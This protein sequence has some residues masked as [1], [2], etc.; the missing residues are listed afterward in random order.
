M[1]SDFDVIDKKN[2][3]KE[4]TKNVRCPPTVQFLLKVAKLGGQMF[5]IFMGGFSF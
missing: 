4:S 1:M 5:C 3:Q 2:K